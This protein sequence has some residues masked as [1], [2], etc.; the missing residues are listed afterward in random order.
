MPEQDLNFTGFPKPQYTRTPNLIFDQLL[1][2]LS[3][4]QL[5]ALLYIVRRT[6][7]WRKDQEFIPASI[8]EIQ[9][10]T[11]LSNRAVIDALDFLLQRRL[12]L[13]RKRR[14]NGGRQ[15]VAEYRLR[16]D[17]DTEA[18]ED[19]YPDPECT[20]FTQA[21]VNFSEKKV[22]SGEGVLN[23]KEVLKKE[24]EK[25]PPT[26]LRENLSEPTPEPERYTD[27]EADLP[28]DTLLRQALYQE[29]RREEAR[30][31]RRQQSQRMKEARRALRAGKRVNGVGATMAQRCAP[32]PAREAAAP[33]VIPEQ[34][35][36]PANAPSARPPGGPDALPFAAQEWNRVVTAGPPVEQWTRRDAGLP[37]DDPD[38]LA[39]LPRILPLCQR[40]FETQPPG[41][42]DWLHFRY[43]LRPARGHTVESWYRMANGEFNWLRTKR[44]PKSRAAQVDDAIAQ[45]LANAS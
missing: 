12:V 16:F 32:A 38:F 34:P 11:G 39:A 8:A 44:T 20:K 30:E 42:L 22:H 15:A 4:S 6:M 18:D 36:A 37:V 5:K 21:R 41:E 29:R 23:L 35:P 27:P 19:E 31:Y 3:G 26:P 45:A 28:D 7:G 10:G 43:L 13:R 1:P 25:Y 40:A 2:E 17:S 24:K 9:E 33:A 14:D